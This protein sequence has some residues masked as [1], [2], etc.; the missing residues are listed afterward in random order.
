M[1]FLFWVLAGL[2]GIM[3]T[4]AQAAESAR[5]DVAVIVD[6]STSMKEPGMDPERA[7]L[8]VAKLLADIVPGELA[9]IRLL[10][11]ADDKALLPSSPTGKTG[12]CT[13]D[14]RQTC[15]EMQPT[16]NWDADARAQRFGALV[17]PRRADADYKRQ[18][19]GHL[20]Q[21]INNSFFNLAFQA[22]LGVFD[23]Q[24]AAVPRTVIWLSDGRSDNVGALQG[25]VA[26]TK[27]GGASIEAIVFGAGD[28]ALP[29]KMGVDTLK[30][31][32]PAEMMNA[33][34]NAFRRIVQA[35]YRIDHQVADAP[36][37]EIKRNVQE[38]WVVVYGDTS[39]AAAE[40]EGPGGTSQAD[41]A[42]DAWASAGAYKVAYFQQPAAGS[43]TV[44]TQG[45]GK[46][47]A[48]AVIQ[49]TDLVPVLVSPAQA[50]AGMEVPL[51]V[52][53]RG[54][55]NGEAVNDAE[56][57]K[58]AVVTAELEGRKL[59][60]LDH[61][62]AG[63]AAAQDGRYSGLA[64]F[65]KAGE[66][67]VRLHL[68]SAVADRDNAATVSVGG[69]FNYAGGPLEI[70]LGALG[71]NA[72]SCRPLAFQ[73]DHQGNVEFELQ[74]LKAPPAGHS[75][76]VRLPAGVLAAD[77]GT[78]SLNPNDLLRVC[79]KTAARVASSEA[80]G[81]PWLVLRVAGSQQPEH[82][83]VIKL[84]WQVQGLSFWELWGWLV[85]S[86]L[87]A[88]ALLFILLGFMLPQRFRGAL[89][90]T[91]VPE[92][93]ELDEQSPQ[94][95]K[96]WRGVGIGFYRNARAY[97]HPDFRLSGKAG[98][99]LAGLYAEPGGNRVAPGAG[100]SLF[101]E[102]LHGDW[103]P[104]PPAGNRC[105]AGDIYRVGSHGPYFRIAVR[106]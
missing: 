43:W 10:D 86:V 2:A 77:N 71:V 65:P 37:F 101:R 62:A 95:V 34:A 22:A 70:D 92:R 40:L 9:V 3:V 96:Q 33:F 66:I 42:A 58:D 48:Y 88:L 11:I 47:V 105:R 16:S 1:R 45:G 28:V 68:Q 89:A 39:L 75:L 35:P 41:Y 4:V 6:T 13:E 56:L 83:I 46:G 30:V 80:G 12:P 103:E 85:W 98:G 76:D 20:E 69:Q 99:A 73:A 52:E 78:A 23:Q 94:P 17:R 57:L 25:A 51:V 59:T 63:D 49:R 90:V 100:V 8:L 7:S 38:A 84:R 18:L 82:Q 97:L 87:A 5:A 64:R 55:V 14:P 60:L 104:V 61:G 54:G 53:I 24:P 106:G 15:S 27:A 50:L 44:K 91:F 29:R 19:E 26:Q 67:P 81:E 32:N 21:R 72:E 74:S 102:T 36:G 31:T 79:L 93:D